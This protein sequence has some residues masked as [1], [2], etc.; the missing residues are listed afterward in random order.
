MHFRF[1]A[2]ALPQIV[3]TAEVNGTVDFMNSLWFDYTGLT[4]EETYK[5]TRSA[6]HPDDLEEYKRK[7]HNSFTTGEPYE[8]EYRFRRASDGMYRWHLGRGLPIRDTDGNV[9]KW[10]GTCTDIHDQ[11]VAEAEVRQLNE[12]LEQKVAERTRDLVHEI[13]ERQV[14]EERDHAKLEL[15]RTMIDTMPMAA[16]VTDAQ[17]GVLHANDPFRTLFAPGMSAAALVGTD[18]LR[19]L[20]GTAARFTP[21]HALRDLIQT[22]HQEPATPLTRELTSADNRVF[23]F[24]YLPITEGQYRRGHLLLLRDISME[25]KINRAKTEFMSLASHQLRTPLTAVRWAFNRLKKKLGKLPPQEEKLFERA[26]GGIA[27]MADTITTMLSISRIEAG[28]M[29]PRMGSLQLRP[30]MEEILHTFSDRTTAKMQ[31]VSLSCPASAAMETDSKL[32]REILENLVSNAVKYTP[33]NGRIGVEAEETS[34]GIILRV[35]D[36]GYGIPAH[37]QKRLFTKFFRGENAMRVETEGTG[38]GL[39]LVSQLMHLLHGEISYVSEEGKGTTFTLKFRHP[40]E[41]LS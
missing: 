16:A 34:D 20:S 9:L 8:M 6:V 36:T 18:C 39:Y 32:L 19:V 23:S 7:W 12:K 27:T 22:L 40:S 37:E 13:R 28:M 10:F 14:I 5:E 31:T 41:T 24:D 4:E 11:K 3:W 25:K 30:F 38:L 21:D 29:P 35:T 2:E 15:L 26:R 17:H 1:L 33:E